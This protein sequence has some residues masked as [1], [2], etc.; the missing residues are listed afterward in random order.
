[1]L[2][3]LVETESLEIEG[4]S[5]AAHYFEHRT[6]R[7]AR[8]Y[9]CE[10]IIGGGERIIIDDDSLASLTTRVAHLAPELVH[11]RNRRVEA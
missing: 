4:R 5:Y 2:R 10:I 3:K 6:A 11:S 1:M 8:R 9:S 7:G